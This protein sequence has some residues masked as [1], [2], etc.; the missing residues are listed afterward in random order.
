MAKLALG[1]AL[2][3]SLSGLAWW[4]SSHRGTERASAVLE[5]HDLD[6]MDPGAAH[7]IRAFEAIA[8]ALDAGRLS[9]VREHALAIAEFFEPMNADTTTSAKALAECTEVESARRHFRALTE[10][11]QHPP[12]PEPQGY[13]L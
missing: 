7:S 4:W 9:G 8:E 13:E 5:L 11:F 1:I 6:R 2:G 12:A 10:A 3:I